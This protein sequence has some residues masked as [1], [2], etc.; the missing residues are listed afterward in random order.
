MD[1]YYD[2]QLAKMTE[3]I[4]LFQRMSSNQKI[5]IFTEDSGT[6]VWY[7]NTISEISFEDLT[8]FAEYEL[9]DIS[10]K[11]EVIVICCGK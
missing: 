9:D 11:D 4:K 2:K 7:E 6:D 8:E 10:A 3:W 1:N 5:K